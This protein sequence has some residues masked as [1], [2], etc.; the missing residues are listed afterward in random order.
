MTP[1]T[2]TPAVPAGPV[3]CGIGRS[4][5]A[6]AIGAPTQ[7][8]HRREGHGVTPEVAPPKQWRPTP[9]LTA[10]TNPAEASTHTSHT[11]SPTSSPQR[12]SAHRRELADNDRCQTHCRTNDRG[13]VD[14][15]PGALRTSGDERDRERR[16]I[17]AVV[18]SRHGRL[19]GTRGPYRCFL[20][21]P[22]V[23]AAGG[24]PEG[25]QPA[26]HGRAVPE[27]PS[28]TP[29]SLFSRIPFPPHGAAQLL[30]NR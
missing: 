7:R 30:G 3:D 8:E 26:A 2:T 1:P 5:G 13:Q 4:F 29:P 24:M 9:I 17:S 28:P 11:S 12:P 22:F 10:N 27:T 25:L 18:L 6:P 16:P 15:A 20:S 23:L 14:I 19:S 21:C